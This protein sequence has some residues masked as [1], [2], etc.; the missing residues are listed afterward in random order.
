MKNSK[1]LCTSLLESFILSVT[2]SEI[3]YLNFIG[4]DFSYS[5]IEE[6]NLGLDSE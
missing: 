6:F 1:L 4:I 5:F 2:S 3:I